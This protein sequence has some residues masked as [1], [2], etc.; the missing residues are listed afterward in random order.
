MQQKDLLLMGGIGLILYAALRQTA[1]PARSAAPAPP[2]YVPAPQVVYQ[3]SPAPASSSGSVWEK[4]LAA[5]SVATGLLNSGTTL[6]N[7][8]KQSKT[9]PFAPPTTTP[10]LPAYV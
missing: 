5:G 8:V 1:T 7:T 6:W 4:L 9:M 10:I 2:R 3:P